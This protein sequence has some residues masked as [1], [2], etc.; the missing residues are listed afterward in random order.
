MKTFSKCIRNEK[1]TLAFLLLVTTLATAI[2]SARRIA[3][4]DF[5][6][7]ANGV[8][9]MALGQLPYRDFD[10]VLPP[11]TFL[12]VYALHHL[13]RIEVEHAIFLS[14]VITQMLS[15]LALWSILQSLFYGRVHRHKNALLLA[16]LTSASVINVISIYPNYVYDSVATSLTLGSLAS[17]LKYNRD[18]QR[19]YLLLTFVLAVFSFYSKFNMGGSLIFGIL[20]VRTIELGRKRHFKKLLTE[21]FTLSVVLVSVLLPISFL[22]L[23]SFI[24]QTIIEPSKFKGVTKLGQ[25]AQYNYPS[26]I[27]QLVAILVSSRVKFIREHFARYG[28]AFIALGL[29]FN[30]LATLFSV[31]PEDWLLGKVFPSANFVYPVAMLLA[32]HCLLFKRTNQA[33]D[34]NILIIVPIYF[35]GTFFSQ[36]WNGSSYSLS[37]LLLV[38]I[39]SIFFSQADENKRLSNLIFLVVFVLAFSNFLAMAINGNRLGYVDNSGVRDQSF[40]WNVLGMASSREDV[41]TVSEVKSFIVQ[42]RYEGTI[43]EF[44]AEDSLHQFSSTLEP[45]NRCLQFTFICPTKPDRSLITDLG[46]EV[47]DVV[48]LKKTTQI[49]RSI[50]SIVA[51]GEPII[52][53]CFTE[54][55][56]NSIYSVFKSDVETKACVN[57]FKSRSDE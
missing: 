38:L 57:N 22:G 41:Y 17:L 23:N 13:L 25:L 10:L 6:F 35:F 43:V 51:I 24:E 45:W 53:S 1:L 7:I 49:N 9:R 26:L 8:H 56:S 44:P 20:L 55:F 16:L 40:N 19:R 12:P 31:K 27:V 36:G 14:A 46:Q 42:N 15:I 48:I 52:K 33:R 54:T 4:Y 32:L 39:V 30:F 3:F 37:P 50:E 5:N 28:L 34:L 29:G 2:F 18:H 47:P 11:F 21:A